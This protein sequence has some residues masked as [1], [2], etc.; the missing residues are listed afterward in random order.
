MNALDISVVIATYNRC[1]MLSRALDSVLNQ[2]AGS[3]RYEVIVVD[4][5][6]IDR[7]R[8]VVATLSE[9]GETRLRYVFE[10]RQG[11]AHARNAGIAAAMAPIVAFTDDD[12][13]VAPSWLTEIKR[14]LDEHP[15]VDSVGGAILPRW[16]SD[17]PAWLTRDHW[18]GPLALQEYGPVPFYVNTERPLSLAAANLAFR[19]S[20]FERIGGFNPA[21]SIGGDHSDTEM[22][23]RLF[24]NN[25]QSLYTPRIL[26]TA[27]VQPERLAKAYHR[28]WFFRA[29]RAQA[30]MRF[31][32]IF[33]RD[34][35][36]NEEGLVRET[37]F[38]T[39][40]FIYRAL[41]TEGAGWLRATV[42]RRESVALLRE[43]QLHYLVG[44]ISR[45]YEQTKG[46]RSRWWVPEVWRFARSLLKRKTRTVRE[47][48]R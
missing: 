40:A 36:L 33:D 8:D 12:V 32:E 34:G 14:A 25:L 16:P 7:T 28:R 24:R 5:N 15:D 20:L 43:N 37:L 21:F 22:L 23:I 6:S 29:G 26:V 42:R 2:D 47:Q 18:V 44:Y 35:R 39:P 45:R 31:L 19:K 41:L 38:G 27:D 13:R 17:P 46:E 3:V 1:E 11:V 30:Q 48:I 4:N 9:G 10:G